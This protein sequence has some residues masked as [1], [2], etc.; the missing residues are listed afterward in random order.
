MCVGGAAGFAA[1]KKVNLSGARVVGADTLAKQDDDT[2][3]DKDQDKEKPA[4]KGDDKDEKAEGKQAAPPSK[5]TDPDKKSEADKPPAEAEGGK[6]DANKP[7]P[8]GFDRR[9]IPLAVPGAIFRAT[10][11]RDHFLTYGYDRDTLPVL[12]DTDQFLAPTRR[13]ANVLTFPAE[14]NLRLAGFEWPDNTERLLH[15]TAAVVEEPL[16]DGHVILTANGPSYRMFWRATTRLWLNSLLY[17]PA[18]RGEG[19]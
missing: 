4:A 10:V 5:A 1:D 12:V 8:G 15:G 2:D 19:D 13:G 6:E 17:A 7:K 11:N 3:D 18:M 9:K 16:G 14:G